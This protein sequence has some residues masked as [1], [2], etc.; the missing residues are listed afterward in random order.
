MARWKRFMTRIVSAIA[1][2]IERA[3]G[4]DALAEARDLAVFV[5]G[6][7]APAHD[8]GDFQPDGVGADVN[9]G[10][11]GHESTCGCGRMLIADVLVS[12]IAACA[13]NG[14][15]QSTHAE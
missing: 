10:K 4:E 3:A 8:L 1:C 5:E 13:R 15:L 12:T 9:R 14:K 11:C 2:G 6:L 7:Q